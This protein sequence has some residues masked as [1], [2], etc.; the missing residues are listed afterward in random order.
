MIE[1]AIEI[2][3]S[4]KAVKVWCNAR[5]EKTAFYEKFGLK[6]TLEIYVKGGID[7]VVLE[8]EYDQCSIGGGG[9][10]TPGLPDPVLIGGGP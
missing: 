6:K 4:K 5:S 9:P 2:S 10:L 1:H 7:F 8:K 3:K